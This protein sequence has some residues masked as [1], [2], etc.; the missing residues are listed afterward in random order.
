MKKKLHFIFYS[1]LYRHGGGIETWASYFF[2]KL[3]IKIQGYDEII[4]YSLK[5]KNEKETLV[6][7]LLEYNN[8]KIVY[9]NIGDVVS[10]NTFLNYY[11]FLKEVKKA[12]KAN[13]VKQ[14]IIISIGLLN[15]GFLLLNNYFIKNNKFITWIRSKSVGE[16]STYKGKIYVYF[17][18]ILEKLSIKKSDYIITNGD[19]TLHYYQELFPKDKSKM[20]RIFNAIDLDTIPPCEQNREFNISQVRIAYTGRLSI[21]KG[22]T[23]YIEVSRKIATQNNNVIFNVY[24]D[25]TK[26]NKNTL[27]HINFKGKY[28]PNDVNKI[29]SE[30]DVVI[31]LNRESQAGGVSHS[32]LEAMANG[33]LIIAWD[34]YTH[35]QVLNSSNSILV[36]EGDL[37]GLERVLQNL[38]NGFY[39]VQQLCQN[40]C[41]DVKLYS[42]NQHIK[43]FDNI[44]KQLERE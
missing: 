40:V 7:E 34:N 5:S 39:D 25:D 31:F 26:L 10:Q 12:L 33:K 2:P 27:E 32:L 8:V 36:N 9:L 23:D 22:F 43:A 16:V 3:S 28:Q 4:I 35:N 21:A 37:K 44:L 18:K 14:D 24:G 13:V 38:L 19:D 42:V 11:R 17:A 6:G 20:S 15:S 1:E 30:N 29:L 41:N